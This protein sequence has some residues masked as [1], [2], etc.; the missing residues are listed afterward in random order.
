MFTTTK[1]KLRLSCVSLSPYQTVAFAPD[2]A[3]VEK[4][5]VA[6]FESESTRKHPQ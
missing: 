6:S 3:K 5:S 1:S 4:A 2:I